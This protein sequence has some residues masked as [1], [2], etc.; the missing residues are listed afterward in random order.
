MFNKNYS[1]C[2][3]F[4]TFLIASIIHSG[5]AR[6][7]LKGHREIKDLST[8]YLRGEINLE[9]YWERRHFKQLEIF[10]SVSRS[11][12]V[13]FID[14]NLFGDSELSEYYKATDKLKQSLV[15]NRDL[16]FRKKISLNT[17]ITKDIEAMDQHSHS[18][19]ASNRK[20]EFSNLMQNDRSLDYNSKEYHSVARNADYLDK[21]QTLKLKYDKNGQID[22]KDWVRQLVISYDRML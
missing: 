10:S 7:A 15:N 6:K 13:A 4:I 5:C 22:I 11:N 12:T 14:K 20:Q 19:L 21:E 9:E 18:I 17:R 3:I 2:I 1:R 16:Y 8:A